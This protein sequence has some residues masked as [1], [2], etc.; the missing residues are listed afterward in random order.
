MNCPTLKTII[1]K[2]LNWEETVVVDSN[3]FSDY[4]MEAATRA[5]EKKNQENNIEVA[6]VMECYEKDNEK[7]PKKHFIYNTYFVLINCS[8]YDKAE[9][10]R[11]NFLKLYGIDLKKESLN[12]DER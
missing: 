3:I 2:C 8:M 10:L 6:V 5:I 12:S 7:N 9:M 1:V 11:L 4:Y